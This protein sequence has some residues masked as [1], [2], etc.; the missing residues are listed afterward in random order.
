MRTVNVHQ[1]KTNLSALLAE[2]EATGEEILICRNGKPVADLVRHRLRDRL[3]PHPE[4]SRIKI[5][6]DPTEPLAH[7]EWREDSDNK[8]V[9]LPALPGDS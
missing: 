8:E 4:M 3:T 2:V 5:Q 9:N 7:D 6:Y 1:A